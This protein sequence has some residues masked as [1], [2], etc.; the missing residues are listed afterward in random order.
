MIT[1]FVTVFCI[2][3]H[4]FFSLSSH[5]WLDE[6]KHGQIKSIFIFL[7]GLLAWAISEQSRFQ[8]SDTE[9]FAAFTE[10]N[11]WSMAR[12][13]CSKHYQGKRKEELLG[14][15]TFFILSLLKLC[16]ILP[17]VLRNSPVCLI[18]SY[19]FSYPILSWL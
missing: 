18:I 2:K 10:N 11:K 12:W 9:I 3:W 17:R 1:E 13:G 14:F 8:M 19:C 16:C 15:L 7:L 5:N 6:D 4:A